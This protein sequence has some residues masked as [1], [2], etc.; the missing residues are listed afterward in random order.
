ME[1]KPATRRRVGSGA[2][3]LLHFDNGR[4]GSRQPAAIAA[5][6]IRVHKHVVGSLENGV[7]GHL[8]HL[9]GSVASL[10]GLRLKTA[11]HEI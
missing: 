2:R 4:V 5:V 11:G 8:A 3:A 7:I 1:Q 9:A 10:P 6:E